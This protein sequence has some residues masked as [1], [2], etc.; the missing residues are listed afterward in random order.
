MTRIN[1]EADAIGGLLV[2]ADE[3]GGQ[4][5]IVQHVIPPRSL[6]APLHTHAHTTEVHIIVAGTMTARVGG[7][8]RVLGL[9]DLSVAPIGVPHTFW[10]PGGTP[11][12]VLEIITPPG[13]EAYFDDLREASG[14]DGLDLEAVAAA[15]ARHDIEADM[16]SVPAL[17][18]EHG[19]SL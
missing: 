16:A 10:N 4:L 11:A 8:D 13:F 9:G 19:L 2:A 3:T 14:P 15:M 17:A 1:R 7:E 18:A 12:R 5:A 6:G